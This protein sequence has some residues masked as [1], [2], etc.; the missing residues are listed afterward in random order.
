V[1]L[2]HELEPVDARHLD[3]AERQIDGLLRQ[4]LQRLG[5][6]AC[7]DDSIAGSGE[8]ALDGAAIELLVIDDEDVKRLAGM[9]QGNLR[10]AE[11]AA[12]L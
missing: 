2:A 9:A 10:R 8:D 11:G 5:R 7:D 1:D 6:I 4:A 12:P 3:V